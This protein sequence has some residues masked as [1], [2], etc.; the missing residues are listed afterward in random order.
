MSDTTIKYPSLADVYRDLTLY[1]KIDSGSPFSLSDFPVIAEGRWEYLRDNWSFIRNTYKDRITSLSEGPAKTSAVRQEKAFNE[2]VERNRSY[3]E[4]PLSNRNTFR[5]FKD[6]FDIIL[7]NDTQVTQSEQQIL[8][9]EIARINNLKK[10]DFYEMRKRVRITHDK[11]ADSMGLSDQSYNNMLDRVSAPQIMSFQFTSFFILKALIDLMNQITTLIPSEDVEIAKPDPFAIVRQIIN[12][13]DIAVD[14]YTNG[15]I[16]PF[17]AGATLER[18][19]AQYLGSPDKWIEIATANNLKFPY[20]DELG[21][22]TF[23]L[24]NGIGNAVIV[25]LKEFSN[26]AINQEVFIGSDGQSLSKR[27]II[28]IEEDKNNDL[29][30]ITLDGAS[31][32]SIYTTTQRAYIFS[33]LLG[34]VN[35]SKFIMIPAPGGVGFQVNSQ[36]PWFVKQLPSDLKNA[37]VDLAIGVDND[38]VIDNTGDLKLSYGITNLAQA[39]NLKVQIK[40]NELIRNPSFGIKEIAGTLK[41]NDVT[42]SIITLLIESALG[43]DDRFE[44][45]D[46][47]G[48]TITETSIFIN[49][50]VRVAG[51]N[52]SIPLTF[53]LPR[54]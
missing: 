15:R 31:N 2:L 51:A 50:T 4:N 40:T 46:G 21:K 12:N 36:D 11:V 52:S 20:V 28:K 9:T 16:I 37:G 38:L 44:G 8:N 23:L 5:N 34:T 30:L 7:I 29:L 10:D 48:Y 47:I 42:N 53:E 13:P 1:F 26:F 32:M 45:T 19:A 35:S 6:L 22:K 39:L 41:N 49:A 14:S 24:V 54:G 17:P 33:Y 3:S 25:S 18:L 27:K 43:G